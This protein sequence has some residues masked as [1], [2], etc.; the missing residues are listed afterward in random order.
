MW[1]WVE[2]PF[3]FSRYVTHMYGFL[4][5]ELTLSPVRRMFLSHPWK[6][7]FRS[8]NVKIYLLNKLTVSST[9]YLKKKSLNDDCS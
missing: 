2:V 7:I 5:K 9:H 3:F 4:M 8:S 1:E 6:L